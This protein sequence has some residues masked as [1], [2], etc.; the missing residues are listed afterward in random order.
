MRHDLAY[1]EKKYEATKSYLA[2][3]RARKKLV[4][5]AYDINFEEITRRLGQP[6]QPAV[7]LIEEI[8]NRES[9]RVLNAIET[10]EKKLMG[11]AFKIEE[12]K[13]IKRKFA[14]R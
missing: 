4:S 6:N 8:I 14:K 5:E 2:T 12:I 9:E 11:L 3:H 1:Y 10:L 7:C 13:K